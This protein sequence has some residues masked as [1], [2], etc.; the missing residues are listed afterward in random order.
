MSRLLFVSYG[1]GH[2]AMLAPVARAAI[3][4]GHDVTYLALT[5]AGGVTRGLGI[6]TLGYDELWDYAAPGAR[7]YG[8][9]LAA[10]LPPGGSV[11]E[12]ESI[13]YLGISFAD[14]AAVEGGERAR[15]RFI[16]EGRHAFLPVA[17]MKRFLAAFRPDAVIASNSPRTEQAALL[18]A[19]DLAM[20]F[21]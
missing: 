3:A 11:P 6:P 13:A 4:A 5:T 16:D 8:A 2:V 17:T 19:R 12:A 9:E 18:A 20:S 1:G 21:G 10:E 15:A 14:L 7:S